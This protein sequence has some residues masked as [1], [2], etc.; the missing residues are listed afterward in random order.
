MS[1]AGSPVA[2]S[3]AASDIA[4]RLCEASFARLVAAG[5]GDG[6]AAAA[7]LADA[8]E[9]QGVAHQISVVSLPD[10]AAR[11]T[12]ADVTVALGRPVAAAD[13]AIGTDGDPASHTAFA[14]VREL[15]PSTPADAVVLAL[16]GTVAAGHDPDEQLLAAA[17]VERRPGVAVP[18]DTTAGLAHSTLVHAPF[19]GSAPDTRD[20]LAGLDDGRAV[21]SAVALAVAGDPAGVARGTAAVERLLRP[22]L[23]GPVGTVGGYGDVLDTLA[24][25]QPGRAVAFALGADLAVL[26]AWR[27]HADCA[28]TA[29]REARTGRYDGLFVVRCDS[30]TPVGT[31]A[32]LTRDYRS[33]EPVV[34]VVDGDEAALLATPDAGVDAGVA[35]ETAAD[36]V[37]AEAAGTTLRGRARLDCESSGFVLAV[38]EAV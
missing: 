16:A 31:V 38:R 36:T 13:I 28:H 35:I 20:L 37:A 7:L 15:D 11:N 34:L 2:D 14:V 32:R 19:S 3:R 10:T 33:P 23:G 4:A 30:N 17:D 6:V 1:T 29:V 26:S 22:R 12:E 8:L 24:R 21:A 9:R 18:T 27:E 5:T 25:S